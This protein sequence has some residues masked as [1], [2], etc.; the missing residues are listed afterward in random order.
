M[1]LPKRHVSLTTYTV[2]S[3]RSVIVTLQPVGNRSSFTDFHRHRCK[4]L[5]YVIRSPEEGVGK[6]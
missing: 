5:R 2:Q 1:Q 4:A 3:N 6:I